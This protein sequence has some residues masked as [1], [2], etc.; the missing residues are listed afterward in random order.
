[1]SCAS[2]SQISLNMSQSSGSSRMLVLP[3]SATTLRLTKRL[4]AIG[5]LL[6]AG[7]QKTRKPLREGS[8]S[9][10]YYIFLARDCVRDGGRR[11]GAVKQAARRAIRA[12][13]RPSYAPC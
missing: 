3:R 10:K 8:Q 1:M 2:R 9:G 6:F 11:V 13:G 4:V 12:A 5:H 7:G